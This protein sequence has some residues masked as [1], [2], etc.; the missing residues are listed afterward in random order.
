MG[1]LEPNIMVANTLDVIINIM[2][3]E[4]ASKKL[5]DFLNSEEGKTHMSNYLLK[6]KLERDNNAKWEGHIMVKLSRINDVELESLLNN[7]FKWEESFEE[8][9]YKRYIQTV[10]NIFERLYGVWETLGDEFDSSEDFYGSGYIYRGYV[11]KVFC[12]QGCFY[13]VE[14]DG[15]IIFQTT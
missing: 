5:D 12:G 3:L 13:R 2:D 11:F 14:K 9:Y 7:F 4:K 6:I 1:K 15:E 8:K 10:S